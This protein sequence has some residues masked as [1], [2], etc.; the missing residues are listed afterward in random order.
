VAALDGVD[1]EAALDGSDAE[2]ATAAASASARRQFS[3]LRAADRKGRGSRIRSAPSRG[4][5][6]W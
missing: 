5:R 4:R 2:A 6:H 1:E 3:A